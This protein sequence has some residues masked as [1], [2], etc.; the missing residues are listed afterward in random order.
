[1]RRL[2]SLL[3]APLALT[4]CA[5]AHAQDVLDRV[6]PVRLEQRKVDE[7]TG[8]QSAE[9]EPSA[10]TQIPVTNSAEYDIGAIEIVGLR[11][12]RNSDFSDI[13][14]GYIGRSLDGAEM[15]V[16]AD[17]L[18]ARARVRYPLASARIAPQG[19][20]ANIL[21]VE[22]DEGRVDAVELKGFSNRRVA[23]VLAT[24]AD[25]D[26][27]TSAELERAILL[28]RDIEGVRI[29]ETTIRRDDDRNVLVVK[30]TYTRFRG[31][32]A[33]DN[34]STKPIGPLEIFGFVQS[35][36][37][38]AHDDALQA[39]F[40]AALPQPDE[41]AFLRLRYA[42][43]IDRMGTELSIA[44]SYSL[45]NPGSYLAPLE[46][47]G[48]SAWVGV[49]LSRPLKRSVDSSIWLE[50][51]LSYRELRQ[52]RVGVMSRL[53]RLTVAR[54]R[55]TGNAKFAGGTVRSSVA[56][57]RGLDLLGATRAGDPL[58]SREDADGTF[59]SLQ[60]D[61]QWATSIAGPLRLVVGV[62]SQLA[63]DPLLVSE[64]IGLG[65]ARF[66]RGYDYSERS[67]DQ[68]SQGYVE[69]AYDID[70]KVGP[71]NGITP[72]VFFDG[73]RVS[74]LANGGGGGSLFSTGGGV[75]LDVD[76]L[77]DASIELAAPL[78]GPR[79]DTDTHGVRIR[80][81]LTRY[82]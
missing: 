54:V 1:M 72:Y 28:A 55:L 73:G 18:A 45:S 2:L 74:N 46:I 71:F 61:G 64:E 37:V 51:N 34:D 80:A 43:R 79:Y 17:R 75:R 8:K 53:D 48:D 23:G 16:L 11:K 44:G 31:Q 70:K 68:G 78:S 15:A 12:L 60:L 4:V 42:K 52:D 76:R 32:V 10:N 49:A 29:A 38:F 22:M 19:L 6:D 25:G 50:A 33:I 36:G 41:L 63:A 30:G 58:A 21:R 13:V 27:V 39:Y 66:A 26:P 65:G 20:K 81:S 9:T 47:D 14:Q 82:F 62:R 40:L 59:T 57:S 69:L 56:L 77:T 5:A 67:G 7:L 3:I 35:N 24:L